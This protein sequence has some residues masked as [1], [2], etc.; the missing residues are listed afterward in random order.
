MGVGEIAQEEYVGK[1]GRKKTIMEESLKN[2]HIS[3]WAE[4]KKKS[5]ERSLRRKGQREKENYLGGR[6][7]TTPR[8]GVLLEGMRA[9]GNNC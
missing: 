2:T 3:R 4:E 5:L 1:S 8:E 6:Q 9:N 7:W